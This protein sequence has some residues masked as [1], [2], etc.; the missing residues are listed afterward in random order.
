MRVIFENSLKIAIAECNLTKRIKLYL[1]EVSYDY[2]FI[3]TEKATKAR[4]LIDLHCELKINAKWP[5][6]NQS[7]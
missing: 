1:L 5:V 6:L 7:K 4:A 2:S 3:I